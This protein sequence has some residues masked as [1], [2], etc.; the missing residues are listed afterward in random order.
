MGVCRWTDFVPACWNYL[1]H[2]IMS[3]MKSWCFCRITPSIVAK[4][5]S[6]DVPWISISLHK[7]IRYLNETVMNRENINLIYNKKKSSSNKKIHQYTKTKIMS[8]SK[9]FNCIKQIKLTLWL[10][11]AFDIKFRLIRDSIRDINI[12]L[13][14]HSPLF[15]SS[16]ISSMCMWKIWEDECVK[17]GATIIHREALSAHIEAEGRGSAV[18]TTSIWSTRYDIEMIKDTTH[19]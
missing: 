10:S 15:D 13:R 6:I 1:H 14:V 19:H 2:S 17:H 4:R 8:I 18:A 7:N 12:A 9:T 11:N 3:T 5:N 16:A